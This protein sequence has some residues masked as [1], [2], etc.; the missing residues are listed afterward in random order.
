[1]A[2]LGQGVTGAAVVAGTSR[3]LYMFLLALKWGVSSWGASSDSI[4]LIHRPDVRTRDTTG[5]IGAYESA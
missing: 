1:M 4:I 5:K 3:F 2:G